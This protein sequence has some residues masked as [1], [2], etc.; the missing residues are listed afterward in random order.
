M[1]HAQPLIFD[2]HVAEV[3]KVDINWTGNIPGMLRRPA[4]FGFDSP[5]LVE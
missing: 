3:Q 1:W 5:E 4:Q 2:N